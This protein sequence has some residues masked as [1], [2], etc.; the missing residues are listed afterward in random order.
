MADFHEQYAESEIACEKPIKLDINDKMKYTV[1]EYKQK[2]F[3]DL[4][5]RKKE[6]RKK[7]MNIN[8]INN[9][10]SHSNSVSNNIQQK[11]NLKVKKKK[12]INGSKT[13]K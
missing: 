5:K 3:D 12:V 1:K 8:N 4:L 6:V 2:L 13:G 9:I 7:I 10:Y 11:Q